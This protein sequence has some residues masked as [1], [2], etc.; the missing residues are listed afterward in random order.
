MTYEFVEIKGA[1]LHC[2]VIGRGYPLVLIHAGI[3]HLDMWD[4]QGDALAQHY[5]AIH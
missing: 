3:A 4:D 5:H 1:K 2:Q